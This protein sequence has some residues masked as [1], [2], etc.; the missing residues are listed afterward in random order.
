MKQI[1]SYSSWIFISTI[2][3]SFQ[4]RAGQIV[5]GINLNT[6]V[7][8]IYAVGIM[9]G[10]YYTTFASAINSIIVPKATQMVVAN[11]NG[12]QLTKMMIKVGRL[13]NYLMLL[14]LSGFFLFGSEFIKLWLGDN[15]EDS[16]MV[17]LLIMVVYTIPMTQTFGNAI[18]EARNKIAFRA[19]WDI[20]S[21]VIAVII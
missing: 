17:A 1:F 20:T 9:L 19:I 10:S 15:Y 2:V 8:A 3:F 6:V 18:I 11:S 5:L 7:V 12:S 16:W 13:N 4:W 14:V 21:M